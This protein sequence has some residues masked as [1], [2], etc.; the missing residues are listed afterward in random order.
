M[1]AKLIA[2]YGILKE[3][4]LV[5]TESETMRPTYANIIYGMNWLIEKNKQGYKNIWFQYSGH[6]YY[7]KDKNG[8]ELDGRDE[9][10]VTSDGRFITDDDLNTNLISRMSGDVNM[11]CIMD[12]CNSGTLLDLK[13]KYKTRGVC[14]LQYNNKDGANIISISGC[15][16]DQTSADAWFSNKWNGAL[17]RK[18]MKILERSKYSITNMNLLTELQSDL[19]SDGFTQRPVITTSRRITDNTPFII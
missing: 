16:D 1:K 12:C 14:E 18:L 9:C 7:K 10:V 17:T 2:E 4:I 19:R 11:I 15:R 5:L 3:D 13:Y 6:G 8:D